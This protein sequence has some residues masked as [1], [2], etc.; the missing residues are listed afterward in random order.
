MDQQSV[1]AIPFGNERYE[2]RNSMVVSELGWVP[3]PNAFDDDL[4]ADAVSRQEGTAPFGV[5]DTV[6]GMAAQ[7]RQQ[8][9]LLSEHGAGGNR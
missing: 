8:G 6:N 4:S 7:L 1:P 9:V 5:C 2:S 3:I